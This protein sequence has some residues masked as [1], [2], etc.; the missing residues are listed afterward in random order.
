MSRVPSPPG[1]TVQSKQCPELL[2]DTGELKEGDASLHVSKMKYLRK[3]SCQNLACSISNLIILSE[4]AQ[5][6]FVLEQLIKLPPSSYCQYGAECLCSHLFCYL[7]NLIAVDR[8]GRDFKC[9]YTCSL[10]FSLSRFTALSKKHE[11]SG[12]VSRKRSMFH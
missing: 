1:R 9:M 5:Q 11:V 10:V 4:C 3:W 12:K 7:S 2:F 6:G 8:E